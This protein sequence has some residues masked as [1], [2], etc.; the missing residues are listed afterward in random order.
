MAH[1]ESIKLSLSRKLD[2]TIKHSWVIPFFINSNFGNGTPRHKFERVH[3]ICRIMFLSVV[4]LTI[5]INCYNAP[6]W[7]ILSRYATQSPDKLPI[8]HTAW[9]TTPG[10]FSI[11]SLMKIG[12]PPL[13]ITLSHW[14]VFPEQMFVRIQV[15]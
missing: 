7:I 15:A 6:A 13:S 4:V 10:L 2:F 5:F 11:K 12:I 14:E 1:N 9:S 3:A 8:A